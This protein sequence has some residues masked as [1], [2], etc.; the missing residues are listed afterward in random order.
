MNVNKYKITAIA[1]ILVVTICGCEKATETHENID[2]EINIKVMESSLRTLQLYFSTTKMYP[3][4]NYPIDVSWQQSSNI[5]DISFMG[6]IENDFCFTAIGPATAV[7]DL[8]TLSN[9]T[10]H[11][12]FHNGNMKQ[13]G[14]LI[15][16][17][18][19]YKTNFTGNPNIRFINTSLNKIPENTIW[20]VTS[21]NE[22]KILSSFL[23]SLMHLGAIKKL[24]SPGYYSINIIYPY[25][26][27]EVFKIEKDGSITYSPKEVTNTIVNW[28]GKFMR[29]FVFQYFGNTANI[30]QLVKQYKEQMEIQ[31]YT[32]KGEQF[33]SW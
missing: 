24:Y 6:V 4:V 27:H 5:I 16:S 17:S 3:C 11:L 22:D 30:E 15:V 18:D 10:Y 31:V 13:S 8:G 28:G 12:N 26:Y 1:L 25:S 2:S 9:G 19:S 21:Y 29:S 14:K 23:E 32:D 33:T 7:I 20:L